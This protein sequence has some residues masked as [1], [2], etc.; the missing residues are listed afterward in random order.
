MSEK[1]VGQQADCEVKSRALQSFVIFTL[2][3]YAITYPTNRTRNAT[4]YQ[5]IIDLFDVWIPDTNL[6]FVNMNDGTLGIF[7]SVAHSQFSDWCTADT[8]SHPQNNYF[9]YGVAVTVARSQCEAVTRFETEDE[10]VIFT[11]R[12]GG[13]DVSDIFFLMLFYANIGK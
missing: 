8:V 10:E 13:R 6:G 3:I 12:V 11:L 1:D 7:G 9:A 4:R 2:P 5:L